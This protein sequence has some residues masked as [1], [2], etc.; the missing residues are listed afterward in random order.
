VDYLQK[1]QE[2][3]NNVIKVLQN[4]ENEVSAIFVQLEQQRKIYNK[5]G[6]VIEL[7]GTYKT[8]N[9]GFALY[10]LL[11]HDNNGDGQ[12]VAFFFVKEETTDAI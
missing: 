10:H 12:P 4:K 11:I 9:A 3:P 1:L 7:D 6:T 8:K 5:Y 2:N